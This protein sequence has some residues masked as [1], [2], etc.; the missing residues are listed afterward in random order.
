MDELLDK[1]KKKFGECF[2]LMLT[3]G[4]SEE[5]IKDIINVCLENGNPYSVDSESDY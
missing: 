2:P 5:E 1:Y 4:M 3:M